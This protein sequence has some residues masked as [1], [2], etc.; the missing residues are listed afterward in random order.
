MNIEHHSKAEA[1]GLRKDREW[2]EDGLRMDLFRRIFIFH[3]SIEGA[4][5]PPTRRL[6]E[7][8]YNLKTYVYTLII[9]QEFQQGK[10]ALL[11][12]RTV[13]PPQVVLA[14]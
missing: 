5:F 4:Q 9:Y 12:L 13:R 1:N 11:C 8:K 3:I 10:R 14:R 7:V 2:T 6:N